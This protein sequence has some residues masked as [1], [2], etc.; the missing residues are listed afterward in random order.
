MSREVVEKRQRYYMPILTCQIPQGLSHRSNHLV[1]I[2][3]T[4]PRS[5][6][7]WRWSAKVFRSFQ[8]RGKPVALSP[9]YQ[10]KTP[11]GLHNPEVGR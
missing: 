6:L 4:L 7:W 9:L 3:Y 2:I 5:F 8:S 10:E 1:R 11:S